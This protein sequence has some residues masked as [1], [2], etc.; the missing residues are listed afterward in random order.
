M[1]G[2]PKIRAALYVDG[3]NLYHA[4]DG[5]KQDHLKWL[6]L[7]RLGQLIIPSHSESLVRVVYCSAY[8]KKDFDALAR[9]QSYVAALGHVGVV[10]VMGHYIDEPASCRDCKRQWTVPREKETDCNVALSVLDDA[11]QRLCDHAYL[12]TADS[13]QAATA[14]VLRERFPAVRLTSVAPPGRPFSSSIL[15]YG[16]SKIQLA[17]AHLERCLF[18]AYVTAEDG[19]RMVRRPAKY[20]PPSG[21]IPPE[22]RPSKTRPNSN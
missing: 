21:W 9:H 14:R 19:S 17:A 6:N 8:R 10:P 3:F 18:P 15:S 13:D 12:V 2:D 16:A 7:W 20:D 1:S 11:Y 5:M 22:M 4:I